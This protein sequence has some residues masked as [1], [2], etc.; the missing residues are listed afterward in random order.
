LG[1]LP[2]FALST[3]PALSALLLGCG[4][5]LAFLVATLLGALAGV[6][7]YLAAF[8]LGFPV[9]A[10]QTVLAS[11]CV[12]VALAVRLLLRLPSLLGTT[13][14]ARVA[15]GLFMLVTMASLA[16]C[17]SEG[18][19]PRDT[20]SRS[21]SPAVGSAP[22]EA[23]RAAA[24]AAEQAA[25]E[26]YPYVEKL[27]ALVARTKGERGAKPDC[28]KLAAELARFAQAHADTM[29]ESRERGGGKIAVE[30]ALKRKHAERYEALFD[31]I[32]E[33]I[34]VDCAS[35]AAVAA[36]ARKIDL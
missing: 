32:L 2:V 11:L 23:E 10:S 34:E 33:A 30:R 14:R 6:G 35:D 19:E 31:P 26:L 36:A 27:A 12:L 25:D 13:R 8:L 29:A 22:T 1:A 17:D 24:R 4:I 28:S 3:L 20:T 9:G 16:A 5:G 7:G 15:L 21:A 18:A